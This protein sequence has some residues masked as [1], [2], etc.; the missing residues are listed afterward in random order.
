M[1]V[2]LVALVVLVLCAAGLLA[3]RSHGERPIE[4]ALAWGLYAGCL[5]CVPV[6]ALGWSGALTR[7]ALV[8][9]TLLVC[10]TLSAVAV[11]DGPRMRFAQAWTRLRAVARLPAEVVA[12]SLRE[13]SAIGLFAVPTALLC[14]WTLVLAYLAP[15]SSWDGLWYHDAIVGFAVQHQG[16][17]WI[18][19]PPRLGMINGYPKS[20]ELPSLW[21]AVLSGRA[22]IEAPSSLF[23]PLLVGATYLLLRH[24]AIT[25]WTAVGCALLLFLLPGIALQMRS[26]HVDLTFI[27]LLAAGLA[28]LARPQLRGRDVMCA[29]L[30]IG[31]AAGV[32]VS[33]AILA[34]P[35]LV[36]LGLRLW[37]TDPRRGPLFAVAALLV[38]ATL[39]GPYYLRTHGYTESPVWPAELHIPLLDMRFDGPI[40]FPDVPVDMRS[41]RKH[42]SLWPK[43]GT[44]FHD[45][46]DNGYGNALP[47]ML[48]LAALGLFL[49][50]RASSRPGHARAQRCLA[51]A[52]AVGLT[53]TFAASPAWWWARLNL[54]GV[55]GIILLVSMALDVLPRIVR[56]AVLVVAVSV[57]FIALADSRPGF[58]VAANDALALWRMSAAERAAYPLMR[59]M[60]SVEVAKLRE[61]ELGPGAVVTLMDPFTLPGPL[62]SERYDN[63]VQYLPWKGTKDYLAQLSRLDARWATVEKGSPQHRALAARPEA[64]Q[65]VGTINPGHLAYR[66]VEAPRADGSE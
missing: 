66:R 24:L 48:P 56:E 22:L 27:A 41:L 13:R 18:D 29:A 30:G 60:P 61:R 21:V 34:L 38:V 26:T 52:L 39:A 65:R 47:F 16:F 1:S 6:L 55:L 46:R 59:R 4:T 32:K 31:L 9:S 28:F 50:L 19:L 33:G 25:R 3:A 12:V 20:G 14:L 36:L 49:A 35:L 51:T 5:V 40:R 2:A 7:P 62:W 17:A 54:H 64:F 43:E 57:S 58:G 53:A 10:V 8:T 23:G 45:T 63:V 15:S 37:L 11:A 44:Q 42:V